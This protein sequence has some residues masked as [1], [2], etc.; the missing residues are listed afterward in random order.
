MLE[1]CFYQLLN[2]CQVGFLYASAALPHSRAART[3]PCRAEAVRARRSPPRAAVV[4]TGARRR[5]AAAVAGAEPLPGQQLL[6][7]LQDARR[8]R[9]HAADPLPLP[10]EEVAVP[11][12]QASGEGGLGGLRARGASRRAERCEVGTS[13]CTGS[14]SASRWEEEEEEERARRWWGRRTSGCTGSA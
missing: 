2:L 13:C 8:R 3:A 5:A 4:W 9:H 14:T 11:A 10:L 1:H 6:G 12:V 7:Q